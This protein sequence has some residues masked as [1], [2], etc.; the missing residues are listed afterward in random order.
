MLD[1]PCDHVWLIPPAALENANWR[2][3]YRICCEGCDTKKVVV[4]E[5]AQRM[6]LAKS[7]EAEVIAPKPKPEPVSEAPTEHDFKGRKEGWGGEYLFSDKGGGPAVIAAHFVKVKE[8]DTIL[9]SRGRRYVVRKV[10]VPWGEDQ[11][12][13]VEAERVLV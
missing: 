11:S 3:K 12:W 8:G 5:F 4:G 9:L 10:V 13:F 1:A 2:K 6:V 7:R